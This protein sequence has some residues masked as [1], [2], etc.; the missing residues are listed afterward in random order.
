[1]VSTHRPVTLFLWFELPLFNEV[2]NLIVNPRVPLDV[3]LVLPGLTLPFVH[4]IS[5]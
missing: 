3:F 2:K 4:G 5:S 1:M